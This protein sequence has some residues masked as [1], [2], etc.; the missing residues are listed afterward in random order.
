MGTCVVFGAGASLANAQHFHKE[1]RTDRNPPLDTTFFEKIRALGITVSSDLRSYAA[2]LPTGS[3]FEQ[4]VAAVRMEEFFKDLFFDFSGESQTGTKVVDA[5]TALIDLYR[6]VISETTDWMSE[7]SRKGGPVGKLIAHVVEQDEAVTLMTFNQDLVL[8]NEIHKRA[9]LRSLW[10]LDHGYGSFSDQVEMLYTEAKPIF[11][12]HGEE[13]DHGKRLRILKLH[14]SLNWQV[15][16]NGRQPSPR[17]LTGEGSPPPVQVTRRR[18]VP[19]QLRFTK[20]NRGR[21]RTLWY[22]W[23]VIVP[24][25]YNK[26]SLINKFFPQV[27]EDAHEHLRQCSRLIFFGYSLP[28]A[29]IEA[30][31]LFQRSIF[32]NDRLAGVDVINPDPDAAARYARLV[33]GKSLRWFPNVETLLK[34]GQ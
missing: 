28:P 8:E 34:A 16:M 15:R 1:R 23:P 14:G 13:C 2:R 21:G 22:M 25:V 11:D 17:I 9:R 5:Y 33:P 32:G 30:E 7:D 6:R 26:Q 4:T 31:K 10:C 3:P 12:S 19:S 24:P 29:D 27:W 18:R 20:P